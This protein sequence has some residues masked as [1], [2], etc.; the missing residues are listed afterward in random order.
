MTTPRSQ[1]ERRGDRWRRVFVGEAGERREIWFNVCSNVLTVR[2]QRPG[3]QPVDQE[4]GVKNVIGGISA[5]QEAVAAAVERLKPAPAPGKDLAATKALYAAFYRWTT[6]PTAAA[7][8]ELAR[9]GADPET[10]EWSPGY[11]MFSAVQGTSLP[12]DAS[13]ELVRALHRAGASVDPVLTDLRVASLPGSTPLM[14]AAIKQRPAVAAALRELG[15]DLVLNFDLAVANALTPLAYAQGGDEDDW[16]I[17]LTAHR[18]SWARAI[19]LL[20][21]W[22]CDTRSPAY[23]RLEELL[24]Y[25]PQVAQRELTALATPAGMKDPEW[26]Q[27]VLDAIRSRRR[28]RVIDAV[29]GQKRVLQH[30]DWPELVRA[31]LDAQPSF[32]D[33]AQEAYN[34][35]VRYEEDDEGTLRD[36]WD[37]GTYSNLP[38]LLSVLAR[39][40]AIARPELDQ[41]VTEFVATC[42]RTSFWPTQAFGKLVKAAGAERGGR[43]KAQLTAARKQR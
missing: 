13:I 33:V 12:D 26:K 14:W 10:P 5:Y 7:I 22:G 23:R 29:L 31:V 3:E 42:A 2:S 38:R 41:L 9:A 15:A 28:P 24:R 20:A 4:R 6:V 16:D 37:E 11:P 21:S 27:R 36:A 8:D 40:E 25:D 35:R 19:E 32:E 34:K 43:F 18:E 39:P 1:P 30:A 17:A